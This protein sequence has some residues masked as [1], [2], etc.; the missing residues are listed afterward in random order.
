MTFYRPTRA[1]LIALAALVLTAPGPANGQPADPP[2]SNCTDATG[3]HGNDGGITAVGT[4]TCDGRLPG[5][6]GRP[7]VVIKVIDCG[8]PQV[9][10]QLRPG[11]GDVCDQIRN[12]CDA[13]TAAQVPTGPNVTT[14]ATVQRNRDGSW[15]LIGSNCAA[16]AAK[17]Q[18]TALMVK[19]ELRRLVPHPGI[20][21]A[22]PGGATLVNLQ[23]LLW[24]DTPTARTLGTITLLGHHITLHIRV[25]RVDWD[26]GDGQRDS[27]AG[28]QRRYD[29]ADG[30]RTRTCP[31]YWGH[32]YAATGPVT[33][34]ATT[35][36]TG[37]YR[38]DNGG[39]Q[40]IVGTVTGPTSTAALTVRQARGVLVPD[41][42]GR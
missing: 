32:I 20:G 22:P 8:P 42:G 6:V 33:I 14:T 18:V 34:S 7:V 41:P 1:A 16:T 9:A 10:G 25:A 15:R 5:S 27:T 37:T 23:T 11:P 36:W 40:T 28:P 4:N 26:F 12:L 2:Q 19:R 38:V 30:C 35:T 21:I 17:P 3:A 39:W 31:G 24:T 13:P 29:P